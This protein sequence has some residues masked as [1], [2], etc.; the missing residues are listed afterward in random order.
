MSGKCVTSLVYFWQ[1]H[2]K[3]SMNRVYS[4]CFVHVCIDI[5]HNILC[6]KRTH[7]EC[8]WQSWLLK[9]YS[10]FLR[11]TAGRLSTVKALTSTT[12]TIFLSFQ[13]SHVFSVSV[14]SFINFL[15]K[16]SLYVH[17]IACMSKGISLFADTH[18]HTHVYFYMCTFLSTYTNIFIL[19]THQFSLYTLVY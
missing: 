4:K 2:F 16:L 9:H 6:T 1:I 14:F 17:M 11:N 13:F 18:T 5:L 12:T 19:C 10:F 3:L 7:Y 8:V 15:A